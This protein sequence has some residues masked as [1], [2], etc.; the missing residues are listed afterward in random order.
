MRFKWDRSDG[1]VGND[2][3]E[4]AN[5]AE[6]VD[7]MVREKGEGVE[8]ESVNEKMDDVQSGGAGLC[9]MKGDEVPI[10]IQAQR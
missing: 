6:N 4:D 2:E 7:E 10:L 8:D 5:V 1:G 3:A 9:A